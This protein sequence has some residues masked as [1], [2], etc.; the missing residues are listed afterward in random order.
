MTGIL[1]IKK[2]KI[3]KGYFWK[4]KLFDNEPGLMAL[5]FWKPQNIENYFHELLN[6][7]NENLQL[8]SPNGQDYPREFILDIS[9]SPAHVPNTAACLID[10]DTQTLVFYSSLYYAPELPVRRIFMALLQQTWPDW[11]VHWAE[12]GFSEIIHR[13][14][15]PQAHYIQGIDS[16]NYEAQRS[17]WGWIFDNFYPPEH[18]LA[19]DNEITIDDILKNIDQE[20]I[21]TPTCLVSLKT[22]QGVKDFGFSIDQGLLLSTGPKILPIL[23][24]VQSI[25]YTSETQHIPRSGILI[26]KERQ[27]VY[28]WNEHYLDPLMVAAL[29]R[30]WRGWL[31]FLH[32]K[33]VPYHFALSGRNPV[34]ALYSFE[35]LQKGIRSQVD[36]LETPYTRYPT[37]LSAESY[38]QKLTQLLD[39]LKVR[40]SSIWKH[41]GENSDF[42]I[43]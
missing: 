32:T 20:V 5:I 40:Y 25:E 39:K 14:G 34:E 43:E 21:Q 11:S 24:E 22:K 26:D 12:Q 36:P 3:I 41:A 27:R 35:L 13:L 9:S 10:L 16:Q 17:A 38:S 7:E 31:V 6:P 29:K 4:K 30:H 2:K 37:D 18:F 28:I 1:Y 19:P 8:W 33:G 42:W 23:Y 15:Y